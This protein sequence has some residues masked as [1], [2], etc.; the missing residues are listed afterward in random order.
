MLRHGR[1]KR[2]SDAMQVRQ[3]KDSGRLDASQ[4]QK[5]RHGKSLIDTS[6]PVI[7]TTV[8]PTLCVLAANTPML[9]VLGAKGADALLHIVWRSR[10]DRAALT[11]S[12]VGTQDQTSSA[13][14]CGNSFMQTR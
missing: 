2:L 4:P 7:I 13:P 6:E 1:A 14:M 9:N 12:L 5:L 8:P 3:D 10:V 11:T